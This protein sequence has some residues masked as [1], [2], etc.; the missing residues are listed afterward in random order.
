MSNPVFLAT[1]SLVVGVLMSVVPDVLGA[2]GAAAW[3]VRSALAGALILLASMED[4][5]H[6]RDMSRR[7]EDIRQALLRERAVSDERERRQA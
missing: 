1:I 4:R 6:Q 3:G 5:R 7:I 2:S